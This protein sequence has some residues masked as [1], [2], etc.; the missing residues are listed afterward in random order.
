MRS[1]DVTAQRGGADSGT[2]SRSGDSIA[3]LCYYLSILR[4]LLLL[5]RH[6]QQLFTATSTNKSSIINAK[7]HRITRLIHTSTRNKMP[8]INV[9]SHQLST[10]RSDTANHPSQV[11]L[12][13]S[14]SAEQ[15]DAY[16]CPY[17]LR[18]QQPTNPRQSQEAVH[19][20]GRQDRARVQAGQGLHVRQTF[21]PGSALL[22]AA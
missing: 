7:T 3:V 18:T 10:A 4:Y 13:E 20:P 21:C 15:L 14:A 5:R 8:Q 17:T 12:K 2:A 1:A 22:L 9:Q 19:R 6:P 11:S 16:V